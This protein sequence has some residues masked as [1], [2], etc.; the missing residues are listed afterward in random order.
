MIA[1]VC[2]GLA[3]YFNLDPVLV[4]VLA[5]VAL[6]IFSVATFVAYIAMAVIVPL[7][8]QSSLNP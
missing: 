5:I 3:K 1:G 2:G 8:D 7:E 6:I 4:R